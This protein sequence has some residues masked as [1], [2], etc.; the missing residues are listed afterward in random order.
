MEPRKLTGLLRN[1]LDWIVMKA[2][3]KD[4]RRRYETANG[5]AADV[6]RY[7]SGEPVQAVPPSA[8]YR[9]R[10]FVRKHRGPVLGAL[11]VLVVLVLGM[12]GTRGVCC[13]RSRPRQ[14]RP[15]SRRIAE[16]KEAARAH[17]ETARSRA[18]AEVGRQQQAEEQRQQR[19]SARIRNR[20][21]CN[22]AETS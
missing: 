22:S 20:G 16:T 5:F 7:L 6:L 21:C 11:A 4:R 2:L 19:E 15:S 1:E 9:V 17:K 13:V 10:K 12:V 14:R 18:E 8:G 3:E